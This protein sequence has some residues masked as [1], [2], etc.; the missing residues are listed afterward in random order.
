V[1]LKLSFTFSIST[2]SLSQ[3]EGRINTVSFSQVSYYNAED[4]N[5]WHIK[6][7]IYIKVGIYKTTVLSFCMSLTAVR[8]TAFFLLN[9][10]FT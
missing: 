5:V 8:L 3:Q 7:H 2:Y 1:L 10:H 9:I 4:V 6:E